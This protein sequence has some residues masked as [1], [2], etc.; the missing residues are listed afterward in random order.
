MFRYLCVNVLGCQRSM[1]LTMDG[2][3][4][5]GVM[6]PC[7]DSKTGVEGTFNGSTLTLSRDTGMNTTQ[8]FV[9]TKRSDNIFNGNYWNEGAAKDEGLFEIQR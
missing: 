9:L 2:N 3:Q 5:S 6:S 8:K 1:R 7:D 4:V